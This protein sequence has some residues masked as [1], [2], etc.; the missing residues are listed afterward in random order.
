MRAQ[1]WIYA[2][3]FILAASGMAHAHGM[4]HDIAKKQAVVVAAGFDDGEPASYAEVKIYSP[5]GGEIE[6]Q[7][8]RTDRNGCFA[9]VPDR[10][11]EWKITIDGGMGHRINAA[12]LAGEV[13]AAPREPHPAGPWP[14]WQG[15]VTGL[16]LIFGIFGSLAYFRSRRLDGRA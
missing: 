1:P 2:W 6:Y 7:K 4:Y 11:G 15:I 16:S 8:G 13:S 10:S 9:F 3:V 5:D 14:K 12:Y